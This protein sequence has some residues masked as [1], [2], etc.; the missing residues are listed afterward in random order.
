MQRGKSGSPAARRSEESGSSLVRLRRS[1]C[2]NSWRGAM[3]DEAIEHTG[4]A[5][6]RMQ[7]VLDA[8]AEVAV[9][10]QCGDGYQDA[11]PGVVQ[12]HRNAVGQLGRVATHHIVSAEYFDH[13]HDRPEQAQQ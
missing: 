4:L 8:R 12:R 13:A 11:E 6:H 3:T 9:K 2:G 7:E 5:F 1:S 10:Y